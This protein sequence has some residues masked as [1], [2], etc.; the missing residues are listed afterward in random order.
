MDED[1]GS[2]H[3]ALADL[4]NDGW[5]DLV[6][7]GTTSTGS[8]FNWYSNLT[9]KY[10]VGVGLTDGDFSVF[11]FDRDGDFDIL[12]CG[13][14]SSGNVKTVLLKSQL[15]KIVSEEKLSL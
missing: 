12:A 14:N 13:E 3:S 8:V 11:D 4:N 1:Y 5:N 15:Q 10:S 9:D 6:I 7:M 2:A